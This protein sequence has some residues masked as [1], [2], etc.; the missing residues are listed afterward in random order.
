MQPLDN[1]MSEPI[2]TWTVASFMSGLF[3]A[4]Y[5]TVAKWG[6][7]EWVAVLGVVGMLISLLMQFHYNRKRYLQ[8]TERHEWE[9]QD[10]LKRAHK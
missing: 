6:V 8:E 3:T 5:N 7:N 9:R 4:L 2:Q 10:R 1:K